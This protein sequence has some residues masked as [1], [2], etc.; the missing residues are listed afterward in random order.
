M[1]IVRTLQVSVLESDGNISI[2][3]HQG[4]NYEDGMECSRRKVLS[5]PA[6]S[7][8]CCQN[9]WMGEVLAEA[10][11]THESI[12]WTYFHSEACSDDHKESADA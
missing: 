2:S 7:M 12:A 3:L 8:V 4:V 11:D 5:L 10:L 6:N 9:C 1:D